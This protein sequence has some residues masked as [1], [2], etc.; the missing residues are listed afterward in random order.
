[1]SHEPVETAV[2][3]YRLPL[4]DL[5]AASLRLLAGLSS[6][7]RSDLLQRGFEQ[8]ALFPAGAALEGPGIQKRDQDGQTGETRQTSQ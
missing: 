8:V 1:M 7:S 6:A 4:A 3:S 2:L 5:G